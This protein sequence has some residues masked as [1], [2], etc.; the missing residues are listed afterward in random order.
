MEVGNNFLDPRVVKNGATPFKDEWDRARQ[1]HY[2]ARYGM[3][4]WPTDLVSP[5]CPAT[6][7]G[8]EECRRDPNDRPAT[9]PSRL[10]HEYSE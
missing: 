1:R 3:I 4:R 10:N 6:P 2:L 7:L 8:L 5:T 9:P